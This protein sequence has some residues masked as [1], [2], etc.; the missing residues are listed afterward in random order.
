M[1]HGVNH[2]EQADQDAGQHAGQEQITSGNTGCQRIQHERDRGRNND[3]QAAGHGDQASAPLALIAQTDH[4]GDAHGTDSGGGGRAG[5]GDGA[6]E[7]AGQDDRAG[8]AAGELAHE[9]GKEV[10]QLLGNAALRHDDAAQD[11]QGHRQDGG[12][13]C[14]GEGV[15]QQLG[16]GAALIHQEN[17]GNGAHDHAGGNGERNGNADQKYDKYQ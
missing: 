5:T 12:G 1:D 17:R 14:A 13:V 8:D 6:V 10:E 11:K 2:H 4:E 15:I 9:V 7:Q 3:A 16:D